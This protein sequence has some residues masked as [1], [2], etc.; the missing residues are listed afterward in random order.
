MLAY[1]TL[2]LR[3][4]PVD[5]RPPARYRLVWQR[6]FYEVWQRPNSIPVSASGFPKCAPPFT[7]TGTTFS[8]PRAGRYELWVSGSIRGEL[9]AFVDGRP[10]GHIRHQVNND[11]QYTSLGQIELAAGS[12]S[13]ATR[14][15]LSRLRPGE[16]GEAWQTGPLL[17]TPADRCT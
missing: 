10:A 4:S 11:G 1:P 9:T 6:R 2:V 13:V 15:R 16:G 5:G 12:H 14:H 3:R 8:A 7:V 17:V